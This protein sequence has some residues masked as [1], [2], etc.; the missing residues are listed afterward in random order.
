M[1]EN[2]FT[3][4]WGCQSTFCP[5]NRLPMKVVKSPSL[6]TFQTHLNTFLCNL[7]FVTLPWQGGWTK[8]SSKVPSNFNNS[9]IP[10]FTS[11]C[12]LKSLVTHFLATKNKCGISCLMM[13]EI[14]SYTVKQ[15][16]RSPHSKVNGPGGFSG[17]LALHESQFQ[18]FST[19]L[20]YEKLP[21]KHCYGLPS[22][23]FRSELRSNLYFGTLI[24]MHSLTK[25]IGVFFSFFRQNSWFSQ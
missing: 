6:E 24:Y 7:I 10:W 18:Y 11:C 22:I 16:Y 9:V 17:F 25:L 15:R 23:I 4:R 14:L 20:P 8:W 1:R 3:L 13:L 5:G 2:F 19:C 21:D 12:Y